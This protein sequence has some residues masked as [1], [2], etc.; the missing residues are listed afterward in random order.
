MLHGISI[1][2]VLAMK[3]DFMLNAFSEIV[4]SAP[5]ITMEYEH[6]CTMYVVLGTRYVSSDANVNELCNLEF[7]YVLCKNLGWTYRLFLGVKK[8]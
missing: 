4:T 2:V 5:I 8:W 1:E 7:I 3:Y 6:K